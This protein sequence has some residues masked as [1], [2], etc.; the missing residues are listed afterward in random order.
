MK[1]LK[2]LTILMIVLLSS[3][4]K[5]WS[6]IELNIDLQSNQK[7]ICLDIELIKSANLKLV[8]YKYLKDMNKELEK[9]ISFQ[10]LLI[11]E[12]NRVIIDLQK[13]IVEVNEYNIR[14]SKVVNKYK[15]LNRVSIS[16]GIVVSVIILTKLIR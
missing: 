9:T 4:L 2:L 10:K 3:N 16:I 11:N 5:S 14:M 6:Q 7:V 1:N 12:Q 15:R 8:E 13:R